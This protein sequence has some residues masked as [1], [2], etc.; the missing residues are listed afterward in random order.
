MKN[1]F[2]I[3][4]VASFWDSVAGIYDGINL[5]IGGVHTQRFHEALKYLHLEPG[6]KLLNIWSRTG[7]AIPYLTRNFPES[8]I[9][10]LEVSSEMIKLAKKKFPAQEFLQTDLLRLNFS[11]GYFENILSLETLEHAPDP[12]GFLKE[13][14]RVLKRGGILVMSLPPQTAELPLKIYEKFFKN[15]GEGPHRFLPSREVKKYLN[16]AGFELLMHRGT[17]LIPAGPRSLQAFGEK[18]INIFQRTPLREFGIRQ[19][20]VCKKP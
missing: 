18:L 11:D 10:N 6:E 4:E 3:E 17:L 14:F 13:V 16:A 20:Y 2:N 19:F 7:G 12:E 9:Y 1:N 5:D 15:H 8:K